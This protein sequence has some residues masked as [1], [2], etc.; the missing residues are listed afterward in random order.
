MSRKSR[1]CTE[2]IRKMIAD[3]NSHILNGDDIEDQEKGQNDQTES[4]VFSQMN[5]LRGKRRK[6]KFR[7]TRKRVPWE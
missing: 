4:P 1:Y 7:R 3:K 2:K 6:K 5:L